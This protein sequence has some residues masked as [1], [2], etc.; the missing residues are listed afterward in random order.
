MRKL[1]AAAAAF[2]AGL[3]ICGCR[4]NASD[5]A[6]FQ[7]ETSSIYVA[8]DGTISSATVEPYDKDYY[9]QEKMEAFII[10]EVTRYNESIGGAAA[11]RNIEGSETLPV[12]VESCSLKDGK[13]TVIYEYLDSDSF[14]SFAREYRD[15]ANRT[16]AFGVMDAAGARTQGWVV[17]GDFMKI[18]KELEG[19]E[20]SRDEISRLDKEMV[21]MVDTDHPVTVQTAGTIR[22]ITKGA[23]L[24]GRHVAEI[25]EGKHYIIFQ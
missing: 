13:A 23:S 22:Y 2:L 19:S 1:R 25:P 16:N 8:E 11:A 6:G 5:A 4:G 20:A 18:G 24:T 17:D 12:S 7:P 14:L 15:E 21:V 10:S 3:M 9:S